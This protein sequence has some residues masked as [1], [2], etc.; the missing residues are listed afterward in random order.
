MIKLHAQLVILAGECN[1][2]N[3]RDPSD[4]LLHKYSYKH[5]SR[6]KPQLCG[7]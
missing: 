5:R 3:Q 7:A 1:R 2:I 6:G 4:S